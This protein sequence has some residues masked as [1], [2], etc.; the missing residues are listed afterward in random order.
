MMKPKYERILIKLSGEALAGERGVGIDLKTVQE[1]AKEIKEVAESGIQIALVIGG[2]NLWR[3]EPAAEAG[4]DRVQA[5]YTGML[6]TVM[7]ALVMADSL[8]QLGVDTRVQT[9]IAMQSV[10]EPYIRGRALRHLEKGRI[11]IFGA[12]IGSPY[13][14][15]DTTAALRAA[16]IEADAILMAKNGVDG[17][18][19]ADPKKDANAVKFN[20]L[21]HR[22]V[23]SRGL[24]IMDATASTL[25]MD[26]DID[27]VVFN[28]NEPGNIKRVVFGEPIGTTV[29]NSS[30][31]K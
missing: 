16:E 4:M 28:M 19:N 30:E 22:E 7:N 24:K 26:N 6:G 27:L 9:A 11:V 23:I 3:G 13:F 17:V 20:E 18:Y 14:S 31:E 29:S 21:T 2:G 15:T 10:A 12:G 25:S 5:D 8:K 1:M